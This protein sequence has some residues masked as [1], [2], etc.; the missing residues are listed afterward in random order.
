[1]S[2]QR[3]EYGKDAA[4][5]LHPSRASNV[6][7]L[8][9]A[10]VAVIHLGVSAIYKSEHPTMRRFVRSVAVIALALGAIFAVRGQ[11]AAQDVAPAAQATAK[12]ATPKVSAAAPKVDPILDRYEKAI[13]GRDA[14]EKLTSQVMLGT[15]EVP[16]ANLTGT[17]MVHEKAPNKF[18]T[19]VIINGAVFQQGFDGIQGWTDDPKN[20]LREQTGPELAESKRGA[21]FLHAFKMRRV[22]TS[23]VVT[24]VEKIGDRDAWVV[25]A[26]VPEGGDPTKM[27]FDATTGLLLRVISQ[28]HDVDGVSE[29]RDEFDDYRDVDGVKVPFVWRQTNGDTTYVLTFSEVHHDVDLSD[30]EFAKPAVQ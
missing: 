4:A 16:S 13:G 25:E 8:Q 23:M 24:G 7:R 2:P 18:M 29:S 5:T 14:W 11:S 21:D 26:G 17:V 1:M 22:Y 10:L 9:I 12:T 20:G 27:Y 6:V 19:A 28:N 3:I 30:S 15:I